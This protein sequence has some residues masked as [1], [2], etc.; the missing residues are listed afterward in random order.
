MKQDFFTFFSCQAGPTSNFW[1]VNPLDHSRV[2][3][4][5]LP[6]PFFYL[7]S[8]VLSSGA[9]AVHQRLLLAGFGQLRFRNNLRAG[10]TVV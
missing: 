4:D 8:R 10:G 2:K 9:R 6:V 3:P 5:Y 1:A 7:F